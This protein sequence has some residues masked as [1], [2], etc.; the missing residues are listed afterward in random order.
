LEEAA[1]VHD[2]QGFCVLGWCE[3]EHGENSLGMA[4]V[5]PQAG[6]NR[7]I[8]SAPEQTNRG[9][10]QCRH[11]LWC[12]ITVDGALI[13]AQRHV[14]DLVPAVFNTPMAPLQ[15]Y[16]LRGVRHGPRQAGDAPA[17]LLPRDAF[18]LGCLASTSSR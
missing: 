6:R 15:R 18:L 14:F 2:V 11:D 4:T 16:H 13:F 7:L 10:P 9:V 12:C 1:R 5:V 3:S 17:Y 8:P